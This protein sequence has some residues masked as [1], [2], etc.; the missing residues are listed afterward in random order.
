MKEKSKISHCRKRK[1]DNE[2]PIQ[3]LALETFKKFDV[4]LEKIKN[5]L[6]V[7]KFEMVDYEE[8]LN[9][10]VFG[11]KESICYL[12]QFKTYN[13]EFEVKLLT[14]EYVSDSLNK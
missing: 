9:S 1:N 13:I 12:L 8:K 2:G 5:E 3:G 7:L 14:F 11:E 10:S 4:N 6:S